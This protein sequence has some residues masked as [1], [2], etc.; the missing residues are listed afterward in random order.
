MSLFIKNTSILTPS[1]VI[2][3]SIYIEENSISS[4]SKDSNNIEKAEFVID[5]KGKIA[6]PGLVNSHTHVALTAMRGLGEDLPLQEWLSQKIWPMEARQKPSD[7]ESAAALAFCEMI[8]SGTTCFAEMSLFDTKPIFSAAKKFGI[9]GSISRSPLDT[10]DGGEEKS[11]TKKLLSEISETT[12]Y[13]TPLLQTSIGTHAPYTCSE[14][15]LIK[16]KQLAKKKGLKY[17]IH[18]SETRKEIFD[19]LNKRG[20]YPYE[21]LDSIGLMDADSIL[22]HGGWLTKREMTIAGK[23]GVSVASCPISNLKLATAGICQITELD[24][25]G[26][27]VCLG[28]D[29]AASNN[30]LN[31]FETMKM[32]ALLQRHH[33]WRADILPVEKVFAFAT[34]NGA[35]ALGFDCGSIEVGKLADIALLERLP[36]MQPQNN[37]LSNLV[38]S[39]G[40]QNV[41]DSIINGRVVMENRKLLNVDEQAIIEDAEMSASRLSC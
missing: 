21:Y 10:I 33:Y 25:L 36:N 13:S 22:A 15:F 18:V 29:S 11:L 38:F 34:V 8:R 4:I 27:N 32:A 37:M 16:T 20:K 23:S 31:M 12:S 40:P 3:G 17:Q 30:S 35:R 28:T 14:E 2:G 39:A 9:R 7:L 5:A 24:K 26:A 6:I 19:T 41:S 1:G